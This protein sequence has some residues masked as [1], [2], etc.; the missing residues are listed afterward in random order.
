MKLYLK[1]RTKGLKDKGEGYIDF[2][3]VNFSTWHSD[4]LTFH[5][6]RFTSATRIFSSLFTEFLLYIII[7]ILC[8]LVVHL[9]SL[10]Y[11]YFMI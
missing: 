7:I 10:Y 2:S 4:C 9:I 5:N 3:A 6:C 1:K 8:A 11:W